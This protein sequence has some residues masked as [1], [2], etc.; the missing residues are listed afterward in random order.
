MSGLVIL[1]EY[2]LQMI[3][4]QVRVSELHQFEAI[5]SSKSGAHNAI[6]IHLRAIGFEFE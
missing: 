3:L 4:F 5:W 6:A 1:H 2:F